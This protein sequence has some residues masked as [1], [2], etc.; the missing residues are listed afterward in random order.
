MKA[1]K[2]VFGDYTLSTSGRFATFA[3]ELHS[4]VQDPQCR[5]SVA[6]TQAEHGVVDEAWQVET[7][8]GAELLGLLVQRCSVRLVTLC[9]HGQSLGAGSGSVARF[10]LLRMNLFEKYFWANL[11]GSAAIHTT[12]GEMD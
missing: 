4:L 11:T 8:P 7:T 1:A 2:L 3:L 9:G 12:R 10:R 5:L 6:A